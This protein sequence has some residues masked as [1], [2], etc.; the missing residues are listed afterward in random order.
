MTRWKASAIHLAI[1]VVIALAVVSIML[2]VWYPDFLFDAMGGQK[3]VMMLISI[4]VIVG[5]LLT[6]I[7]YRPLKKGLKF[8]LS[9]IVVLQLAALFYGVSVLF[10]SRP[11]FMVFVKDRI[12]IVTALDIDRESLGK[13]TDEKYKSLPVTGP[14][15]VAAKVP[16][17]AKERERIL[18]SAIDSG[19]DLQSFPEYYQPYQEQIETIRKRSQPLSELRGERPESVGLIDE[20]TARY[21]ESA[22]KLTFLPIATQKDRD[23]TAVINPTNGQILEILKIDPWI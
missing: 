5:P 14:K 8:D 9:V 11:V 15:L 16:T 12:D 18:L 19:R 23:L 7:V 4:D 2:F 6:L 17:A 22:S 3:I 1:C 13:V 10:Q 21:G 20:V